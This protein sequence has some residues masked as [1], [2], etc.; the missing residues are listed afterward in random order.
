MPIPGGSTPPPSPPPPAEGGCATPDPFVGIPGLIG[1]CRDGGWIPVPGVSAAGTV[2]LYEGA[3]GFWAIIGDDGTVYQPV[4]T[5][6]DPL[7]I[8][9]ARV[10]F[11]GPIVGQI[12]HTPL[13]QLVE[14]RQIT[15]Q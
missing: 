5:L 1:V 9:G 7:R 8:P 11:S 10:S 15:R 14:L 13:I 6:A 2:Q 3:G 4:P 12:L